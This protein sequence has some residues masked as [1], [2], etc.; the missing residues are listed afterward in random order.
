[1]KVHHLQF[2]KI[3]LVKKVQDNILKH[4]APE[5]IIIFGYK[6]FLDESDISKLSLMLDHET[7]RIKILRK[8][9]AI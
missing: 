9:V 2:L 7:E 8:L 5:S 3:P 6:M 1:M 4:T